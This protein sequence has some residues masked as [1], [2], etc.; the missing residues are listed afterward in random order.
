MIFF[1]DD[2]ELGSLE[3]RVS[4][5][6]GEIKRFCSFADV[7]NPP[8]ANA[9]IREYQWRGECC[10]AVG[11]VYSATTA[12]RGNKGKVPPPLTR[13]LARTT[14]G[15]V[16]SIDA[17]QVANGGFVRASVEKNKAGGSEKYTMFFL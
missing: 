17:V 7:S 1:S 6:M 16:S 14:D 11:V 9:G 13:T 12:K 15:G 4:V 3:D 10:K 2:D 8:H 5:G